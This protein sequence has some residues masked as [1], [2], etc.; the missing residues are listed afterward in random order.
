[1]VG[2]VI[3]GCPA[4]TAESAVLREVVTVLVQ[5][6]GSLFL[7]VR[8]FVVEQGTCFRC[9]LQRLQRRVLGHSFLQPDEAGILRASGLGVEPS[10]VRTA[11][12]RKWEPE[13][14]T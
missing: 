13:V 12:R 9:L 3:L 8:T 10:R 7:P 14:S 2:D 11:L 5:E 6:L 1:M 4:Q